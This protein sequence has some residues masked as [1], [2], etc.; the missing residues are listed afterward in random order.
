MGWKSTINITREEALKLCFSVLSTL[1]QK[2]NDELGDILESL[3]YG[4]DTNLPY[5][6]YNFWITEELEDQDTGY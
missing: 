3:G 4:D 2:S 1:H 6:G 5:Y